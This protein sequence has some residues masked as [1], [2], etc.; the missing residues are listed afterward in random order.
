MLLSSTDFIGDVHG[1]LLRLRHTL[2]T[3]GYRET[4]DSWRHPDGR[5]AVF[6]GDL[7]D[8]GPQIRETVE[9]V[10]RMVLAGEAECLLGNHEFNLLA[11]FTPAIHRSGFVRPH[12]DKNL[13]QIKATIKDYDGYH[14][15]LRTHLEWFYSLPLFIDTP[16]FVAVHAAWHEAS[17]RKLADLL[18]AQR[19][20]Q[21]VIQRYGTDDEVLCTAIDTLLKGP[22]VRLPGALQLTDADGARRRDLRIAWWQDPVGTTWRQ[23]AAKWPGQMPD[24]PF[25]KGLCRNW[26]GYPADA[27]PVFFGHYSMETSPRRISHNIC[28]LDFSGDG[29]NRVWGVRGIEGE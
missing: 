9:L 18:P 29:G 28:C 16:E 21:D 5:R 11:W 6:I 13:R 7:V 3:L 2:H 14:A 19:L 25:P 12:N 24:K 27:K 26:W 15:L 20:T 8:R 4:A 23:M 10:R 17:A 1:H 22:E